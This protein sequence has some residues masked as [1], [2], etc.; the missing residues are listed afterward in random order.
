MSEDFQKNMCIGAL[1]VICVATCLVGI[2]CS[3]DPNT[4]SND[5]ARDRS[6]TEAALASRKCDDKGVCCYHD[7]YNRGIS[8]VVTRMEIT[9]LPGEIN[10]DSKSQRESEIGGEVQSRDLE[11]RFLGNIR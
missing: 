11:K 3:Q 4:I 10:D 9:V 1:W 7:I 5:Y 6:M 8:C 2:S